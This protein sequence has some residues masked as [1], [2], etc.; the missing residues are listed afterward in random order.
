MQKLQEPQKL[1]KR[2]VESI[3]PQSE[4]VIIRDNE[5]QGFRLKVTPTGKRIYL[6]YY[7]NAEGRQRKPTIGEHG[8]MTCEQARVIAKQWLGQVAEGND[9]SMTK[10]NAYKAL[11]VA[12]LAEKYLRLHAIHKKESSRKEDER[13][14]QKQILPKIGANKVDGITKHD[15]ARLHTNMSDTPISANRVLALLK[16]MFKLGIEW[17][18]IT[19][20][21]NHAAHVK[22]F[23]E[24]SKER[25]LSMEELKRLGDVLGECERESSEPASAILAVRLLI[26][27]AC[28]KSEILT[29]Q[30]DWIDFTKGCIN[31]PDSKTGKKTVYLNAPALELLTHAP[32]LKNNPFVVTG[33]G[34]A[35][36]WVNLQKAWDRIRARAELADVRLHDLRHSFASMAAAGGMSLYMISKLLSHANQS[37]TERYAHLLGDPV[38]EASNSVGEQIRAVMAGNQAEIIEL[39]R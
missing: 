10:Q 4:D 3:T 21:V 34:G 29:L 28:R 20:G 1:T 38:R 26:F 37:T 9:P 33:K 36:R 22:A 6:L 30:W 8:K 16:T 18:D 32:R 13:L 24:Q 15:I 19:H 7:R 11:S 27:T 23:K 12:E 39:K 35:G 2:L 17:G 31:F 5:L 25:F 14:L